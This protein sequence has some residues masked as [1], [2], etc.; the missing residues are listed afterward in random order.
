MLIYTL[1]LYTVPCATTDKYD[2]V[3]GEKIGIKM[4]GIMKAIRY[5]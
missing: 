5:I 1:L 3:L 2:Q 4:N